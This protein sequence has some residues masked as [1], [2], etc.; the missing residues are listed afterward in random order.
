MGQDTGGVAGKRVNTGPQEP[1]GEWVAVEHRDADG[2]P[3]L[4]R[5]LIA[6]TYRRRFEE[7]PDGT[8][9]RVHVL[10][11]YKPK[12]LM[13]VEQ[14]IYEITPHARA[15]LAPDRTNRGGDGGLA[16][17]RRRLVH[18]DARREARDFGPGPAGPT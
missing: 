18:G 7:V 1:Q 10:A 5:E 6:G 12:A 15:G 3:T 13:L 9:I 14:K 4:P 2:N 16:R 11:G 17:A 8:E